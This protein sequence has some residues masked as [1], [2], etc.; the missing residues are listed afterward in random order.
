MAMSVENIHEGSA[1][2]LGKSVIKNFI[3]EWSNNLFPSQTLT[4]IES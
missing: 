3:I 1:D 2:I 4:D